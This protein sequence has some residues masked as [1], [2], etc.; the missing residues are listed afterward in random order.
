MR[1][2]LLSALILLAGSHTW[3]GFACVKA[4]T[5]KQALKDQLRLALV[6]YDVSGAVSSEAFFKDVERH[7]QQAKNSGAEMVVF[8]ELFV[9]IVLKMIKPVEPEALQLQAMAKNFPQYLREFQKLAQKYQIHLLAGSLPRQITTKG[10][11]SEIRNTAPFIFPDGKVI[12]QDKLT[13]TPDEIQWQWSPGHQMK[14][15]ETPWGKTTVLICHDCEVPQ[16]SNRLA[17]E[18]PALILI[19]SMTSS[20]SGFIRV[21]SSAGTRA[22]EH[23]NYVAVTGTVGMVDKDWNNFAQ[24]T[25]FTPSEAGFPWLLKEGTKNASEI[26]MVDFDMKKLRERRFQ[27]GVFP[28]RSQNKQK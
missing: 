7:I 1:A 27:E 3:A 25:A 22:I 12:L 13:L 23:R 15:I 4:L 26:L 10:K 28:A 8:P 11:T 18:Y 2:L 14:L 24:A 17:R 16:H 6:Q 5:Q 19:P 21:R 9:L 20:E